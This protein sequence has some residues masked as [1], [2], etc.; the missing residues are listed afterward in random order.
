MKKILKY[1]PREKSQKMPEFRKVGLI[2]IIAV[3]V[4]GCA[5]IINSNTQVVNLSTKCQ[6]V[7]YPS[8]CT[9]A[10]DNKKFSVE[11]P[12]KISLPRTSESLIIICE[13]SISGSFGTITYPFLSPA[14]I[15]NVGLG[16]LAG[17]T[18]DVVNNRAWAYPSSID[19]KIPWC[20][21]IEK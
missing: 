3:Y 17:A 8:H 16:G 11:T 15:A 1:N 21:L 10:S 19:I 9:V 4:S 6:D 2:I 14:F 13:S 5:S 7:Y 20:S 18:I 12:A